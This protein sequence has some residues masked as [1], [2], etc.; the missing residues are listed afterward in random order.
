VAKRKFVALVR[1]SVVLLKGMKMDFKEEAT[2]LA[3]NLKDL[4]ASILEIGSDSLSFED[5]EKAGSDLSVS[6]SRTED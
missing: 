2:S 1:F 3:G 6:T 5:I 4:S